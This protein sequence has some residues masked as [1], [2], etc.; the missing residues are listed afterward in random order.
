MRAT[1]FWTV[2]TLAG[3]AMAGL[4]YSSANA[5][6]KAGAACK[7]AGQTSSTAGVKYICSKSGK[8]FVWKQVAAAKPSAPAPKASPSPSASPTASPTPTEVAPVALPT[9]FSDLVQN[10]KGISQAAWTK[11]NQTVLKSVSKTGTFDI[12]TGPKTKPYF[13]DYQK[14]A[15]FVSRLFPNTAEP[16]SNIVIRYMYADLS[17]AEGK[18]NEL[19]P[20]T[21]I[22]RLARDEG[23]RLLTSNCDAGRATCEGSKQLTLTNGTS[24]VLQGVPQMVYPGDLAGKDRFYGGMLEAHE[25]FHALQRIP[26]LGIGIQQKDYPPVWFVEG[27]AEWVQNAA[28]NHADFKKYKNYFVLD[29]Q[30]SCRALKKSDISRI[31][32]EATNSSF[33]SGYEYFL[34]YNLGS[35]LIESLVA[36]SNPE[37]IMAMYKEIA[38]RVGFAAAFKSVYG[39]EWSQAIP[40]LS[41]AVYLNLQDS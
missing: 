28:I 19:L 2:V 1:K 39:I 24:L 9:N 5:A 29:C 15:S 8:K 31:L 6:V 27:S 35:I 4:N 32:Q 18:V 21:E 22:E 26:V 25:Y 10:R 36:I 34:N 12:Y 3:F 16:A 7:K 13:D 33:P 40:I 14:A 30:S 17:W 38:T 23:G 41:E 20:K 37:S 11:V